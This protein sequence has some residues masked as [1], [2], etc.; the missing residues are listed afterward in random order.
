[1]LDSPLAGLLFLA[2]WFGIG[3]QI[4]LYLQPKFDTFVVDLIVKLSDWVESHS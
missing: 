1:M 2:L 3:G 4:L